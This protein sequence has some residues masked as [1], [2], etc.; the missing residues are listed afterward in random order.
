MWSSVGGCVLLDKGTRGRS[1]LLAFSG[2]TRKHGHMSI[3]LRYVAVVC[4]EQDG[5]LEGK[6]RVCECRH[7]LFDIAGR[8]ANEKGPRQASRMC[9]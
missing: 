3:E 7:D 1:S 4:R 2:M 6:G 8:D 5:L 9:Q